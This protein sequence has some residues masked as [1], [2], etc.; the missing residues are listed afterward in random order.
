MRELEQ[1]VVEALNLP[2]ICL[3]KRH[4]NDEY[5]YHEII[6]TKEYDNRTLEDVCVLDNE[7][8]FVEQDSG[9]LQWPREFEAEVYR[10]CIRY[11][12]PTKEDCPIFGESII[13]DSRAKFG[14]LRQAI[15]EKHGLDPAAVVFKRNSRSGLELKSL[16]DTLKEYRFITGTQI[17]LDEGLPAQPGEVRILL[18]LSEPTDP[19]CLNSFNTF[20]EV[21]DIPVNGNLKASECK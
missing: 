18:H 1:R 16:I 11:N 4:Q 6:N 13:F 5:S 12:L 8:L 20:E 7:I 14:D 9:E 15:C 3:I 19:C 17:Y 10:V 21:A 2:N